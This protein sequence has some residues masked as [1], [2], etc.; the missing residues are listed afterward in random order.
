LQWKEDRMFDF[1]D[2]VVMVT[3]AAGNLGSAV[4]RASLDAGARSCL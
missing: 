4:A 2:H 1:T 3:G